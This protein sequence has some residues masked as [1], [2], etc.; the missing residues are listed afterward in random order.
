MASTS[1]GEFSGRS[2]RRSAGP[3][4]HSPTFTVSPPTT[5][6]SP[7]CQHLSLRAAATDIGKGPTCPG[8]TLRTSCR[9]GPCDWRTRASTVHFVV[10][11][12]LLLF[13]QCA[14]LL[15]FCTEHVHAPS[16]SFRSIRR[17]D[18]ALVVES[19]PLEQPRSACPLRASSG[20]RLLPFVHLAPP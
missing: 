11:G 10:L 4:T 9:A 17:Q 20:Q 7:G 14:S 16:L 2:L 18:Q 15:L 1:P 13:G 6:A 5:V 19:T 8:R 3:S 12:E